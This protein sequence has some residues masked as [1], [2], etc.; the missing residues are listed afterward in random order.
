M[1][2]TDHTIF[3]QK[4]VFS[5]LYIYQGL[6]AHESKQYLFT[7]SKKKQRFKGSLLTMRKTV[8][9]SQINIPHA[10]ETLFPAAI[11]F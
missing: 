10:V 5:P 2:I 7:F 6:N 9:L 4:C 8:T 3:C 11:L 1:F